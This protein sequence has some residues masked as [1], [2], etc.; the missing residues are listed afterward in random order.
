MVRLTVYVRSGCHLCDDMLLALAEW[1]QKRDVELEVID[2]F[3][4]PALESAY[5]TKIPVL[6]MDGQEICHYYLDPV[7]LGQYIDSA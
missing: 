3:D 1:R 4:Q 6:A 5:G 2:I 7:A